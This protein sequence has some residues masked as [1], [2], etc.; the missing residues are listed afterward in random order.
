MSYTVRQVSAI[1]GMGRNQLQQLIMRG[2]DFSDGK[3]YEKTK[4]RT[5]TEQGVAC[6]VLVERAKQLGIP[7]PVAFEHIRQ[8]IVRGQLTGVASVSSGEATI[9]YDMDA[10]TKYVRAAAD[11]LGYERP[12][13]PEPESF[14]WLPVAQLGD[15][16]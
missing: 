1:L 13:Q 15:R 6:V 4:G 5:F 16:T 2:V 12:A 11:A 8:L 3:R 7:Y 10:A 14:P 9:L